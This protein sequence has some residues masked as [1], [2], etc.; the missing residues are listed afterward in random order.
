MKQALTTIC[1][2]IALTAVYTASAVAQEDDEGGME[3][4]PAVEEDWDTYEP[5][6]DVYEIGYNDYFNDRMD[7]D[8]SDRH[9]YGLGLE[10]DRYFTEKIDEYSPDSIGTKNAFKGLA[11]PGVQQNGFMTFRR[12]SPWKTRGFATGYYVSKFWIG[13]AAKF[14]KGVARVLGRSLKDEFIYETFGESGAGLGSLWDNRDVMSYNFQHVIRNYSA[15]ETYCTPF[16]T[17]PE[18]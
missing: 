18:R 14:A 13:Y 6:D 10:Y 11:H 8:F 4:E 3:Q 7:R 9:E 5:P 12:V 16:C 1:V 15:P 17:F 2:L